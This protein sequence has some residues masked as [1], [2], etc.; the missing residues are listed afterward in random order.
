MRPLLLASALLIVAIA[1]ANRQ[2]PAEA[3]FGG[4]VVADATGAPLA[5][6]RV[7]FSGPVTYVA[8]TDANGM[9]AIP[10]LQPGEYEV[11]I[12]GESQS[13]EVTDGFNV[14]DLRV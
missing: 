6:T 5:G 11:E 12:S 9:F 10:R 8:V 14:Q 13:V 1:A 7:T 2:P 4:Y 3:S